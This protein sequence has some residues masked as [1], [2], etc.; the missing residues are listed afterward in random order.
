MNAGLDTGPVLLCAVAVEVLDPDF[1][2][3]FPPLIQVFEGARCSRLGLRQLGD[4]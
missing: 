1:G 4:P 3:I 2:E